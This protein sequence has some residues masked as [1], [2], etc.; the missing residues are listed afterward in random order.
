MYQFSILSY[1]LNDLQLKPAIVVTL[2][3]WSPAHYS[4]P[5]LLYIDTGYN[6]HLYNV[7]SDY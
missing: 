4:H 2:I 5:G 3:L 6:G 1:G 7:V